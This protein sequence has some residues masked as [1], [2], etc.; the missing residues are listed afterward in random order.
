MTTRAEVQTLLGTLFQED[1]FT[2][3]VRSWPTVEDRRL[4][5]EVVAAEGACADCLVPKDALTGIMARK[6]DLDSDVVIDVTYP[7]DR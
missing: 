1:G 4:A 6:L 3:E 5:I 7:A 2:A